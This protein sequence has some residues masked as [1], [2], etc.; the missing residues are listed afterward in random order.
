MESRSDE[1]KSPKADALHSEIHTVAIIGMGLM[2]GALGLALKRYCPE[3]QVAGYARREETRAQAQQLGACDYVTHSMADAVQKADLIVLCT[4]ILDIPAL[5]KEMR[6]SLKP[7]AILTDVGS[8]K[9]VLMAE[10][11]KLLSDREACF[12]GSHP[13]AGSERTGIQSAQ[14]DLY[15]GAVVI[16]TPPKDID[17]EPQCEMVQQLWRLVGAHVLVADAEEHDAIV[18]GTSHVP[19][20][21][22]ALLV[23]LAARTTK[24][25]SAFCGTGFKDSTRIA[26]GSEWV[27]HDI[28]KSNA[29]AISSDLKEVRADIDFLIET[30]ENGTFDTIR[31]MLGEAR[32]L[33]SKIVALT[34]TPVTG[35]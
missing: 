4:P 30:I 21:M 35:E 8:T 3:I 29:E 18:S 34:G 28:V 1:I 6:N 24:E 33:R 20:L 23:R 15:N 31:D 7:G 14:A 17:R 9:A 10:V 26:S 32:E 11:Q 27:W 2:G 13:M 5:V 22:A 19:H 12:I 16:V 25:P